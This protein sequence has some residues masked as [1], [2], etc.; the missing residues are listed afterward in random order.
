MQRKRQTMFGVLIEKI[1]GVHWGSLWN[2]ERKILPS[3]HFLMHPTGSKQIF[4][5]LKQISAQILLLE[6]KRTKRNASTR[7]PKYHVS[8]S[9]FQDM[10]VLSSQTEETTIPKHIY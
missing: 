7:F 4:C 5:C 8:T 9:R 1:G 10:I 3:S 6:A 2:L